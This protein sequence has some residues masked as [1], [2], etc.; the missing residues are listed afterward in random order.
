MNKDG[1]IRQRLLFM[2][3]APRLWTI[4]PIL[5][6]AWLTGSPAGAL[7]QI[8]IAQRAPYFLPNSTT[9]QA[10]TS[11]RWKNDT[12]MVHTITADEC[13]RSSRCMFDS[14]AIPP[15]GMYEL[16]GLPPGQYSYHCGLHPYMRGTLTVRR[17]AERPSEILLLFLF[18]P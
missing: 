14:G 12:G 18:P 17:S 15:H 16:P 2:L 3:K 1:D 11:I 10:G 8:Q 6:F 9:V 4:L 5:L 7:F 13:I